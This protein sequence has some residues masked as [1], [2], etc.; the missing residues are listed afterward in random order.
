[1]LMPAGAGGLPLTSFM[2]YGVVVTKKTA[3][4]AGLSV[5]KTPVV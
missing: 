1:M 2:S 3:D 4:A 5:S